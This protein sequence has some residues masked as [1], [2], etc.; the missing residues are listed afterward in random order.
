MYLANGNVIQGALLVATVR[1]R[2]GRLAADEC[3]CE[4]SVTLVTQSVQIRKE[5]GHGS[6][7]CHC[8]ES[9]S[10]KEEEQMSETVSSTTSEQGQ[11]PTGAVQGVTEGAQQQAG[12]VTQA[13]PGGVAVAGLQQQLTQAV[14]PILASLQGQIT[15]LV[16][17]QV[18]Q[19]LDQALEPVRAHLQDRLNQALEPVRQQLQQ[20]VEQELQEVRNSLQQEMEQTLEPIRASL[21]QQ[22]E[23]VLQSA[24][25]STPG[26][27]AAR[28]RSRGH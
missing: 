1:R 27:T 2:Q 3:L 8:H 7:L 16:E 20:Q 5:L 14:Q 21:H 15:Q 18:E 10:E 26:S 19:Q 13:L 28:P 9:P 23:Q 6:N 11:N 12:Q 17:Q 25:Q 4:V 24:F 22:I